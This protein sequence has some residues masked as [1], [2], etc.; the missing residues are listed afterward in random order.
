MFPSFEESAKLMREPKIENWGGEYVVTPE[1]A[2]VVA[3]STMLF[4]EI[5]KCAP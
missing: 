4:D 5:S 2:V 3:N 1:V